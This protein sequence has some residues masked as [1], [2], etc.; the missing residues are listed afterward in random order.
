MLSAQ[1][2]KTPQDTTADSS[3]TP[4]S[5][6]GKVLTSIQGLQ[7]RLDDFSVDEVTRAHAKASDL[8][9]QLGEL[10]ARLHALAEIKTTFDDARATLAAL[11]EIKINLIESD[12]LE[13]HPHVRAIVEA[14]KLI[15]AHRLKQA[16]EASCESHSLELLENAPDRATGGKQISGAAAEA[17]AEI[18]PD[19]GEIA[20]KTHGQDIEANQSA[21]VEDSRESIQGFTLVNDP[22]EPAPTKAA[23]DFAD[24]KLEE[25]PATSSGLKATAASQAEQRPAE[26]KSETTT[27]NARFNERLLNELIDTYGEFVST[28]PEPLAGPI[29]AKGESISLHDAAP[30][31]TVAPKT[32]PTAEAAP[33]VALVVV[34]AAPESAPAA[35]ITAPE[36][37]FV[38]P[39]ATGQLA[40]PSPEEE[41]TAPTFEQ[42]LPNAK[43]RGEIDQQLKSIIKDYGQVDLYS[44]G[45]P[46]N[47]K[48][49]AIAAAALLALV[50]G[51]IYFFKAPS[52][53]PP[54][55][56]EAGIAVETAP[57]TGDV[58]DQTQKK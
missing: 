31:P 13:N 44:H 33:S 24:F 18:L 56:V 47:T 15:R 8:I 48:T 16:A 55:P 25:P 23:Y 20:V 30:Q 21:P 6:F 42:S 52:T 40:L 38:E 32:V 53:N 54:A 12:N 14:G 26:K 35:N 27:S 7:Q 41:I 3:R 10:Q 9:Q 11:P 28:K 36:P 57:N 29:A 17:P 22:Y 2:Q 50:L 34:D 4:V 1:K 39:I 51:G 43:A 5:G 37:A 46:M 45:K 19:S 49:T 58:K